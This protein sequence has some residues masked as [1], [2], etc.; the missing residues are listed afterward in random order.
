MVS[1]ITKFLRKRSE[2]ECPEIRRIA[3]DYL[4]DAQIER[5]RVHL[6][7]CKD[8]LAFFNTLVETIQ[9]LGSTKRDETAP[10][11]L[12]TLIRSRLQEQGHQYAN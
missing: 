10:A 2:P 12:K 5:I 1:L 8:C 11:E 7:G 3:S 9:L 4:D 6:D